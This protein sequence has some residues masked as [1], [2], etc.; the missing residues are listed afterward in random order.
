MTK[1][2][3]H[4]HFVQTF[5]IA[6]TFLMSGC[7]DSSDAITTTPNN[8]VPA[9]IDAPT[10]FSTPT[11][12]QTGRQLKITHSG[13]EDTDGVTEL[14]YLVLRTIPAPT[15]SVIDHG[16][17]SSLSPRF[18]LPRSPVIATYVLHVSAK[19]KNGKTN[20]LEQM[21]NPYT[22]EIMVGATLTP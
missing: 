18:E 14:T 20:Q 7:G 3:S 10:V 21:M 22:I 4:R 13:I 9:P 19:V 15:G 6:A 2:L 11:F 16:I 12:T 17:F 8:S 5:T 1:N